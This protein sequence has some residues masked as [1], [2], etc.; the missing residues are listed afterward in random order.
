M[1]RK[2]KQEGNPA[3]LVVW[4][5][6]WIVFLLTI[7]A[8]SFI[9]LG[10]LICEF[11]YARH[12]RTPEEV[13]ILRDAEE[14]RELSENLARTRAID[15]RLGQIEVEGQQLRRRKDGLFHA[16]S[17]LGAR[18]NAEIATL[19]EERSD[20]QAICHELWQLPEQRLREWS[21]P[22]ARLLGFRWAISTYIACLAYGSILMP[23]SAMTLH[24]VILR[25]LSDSLPAVSFPLYGAMALASVVAICAGGGAYVFYSRFIQ[26]HY[27]RQL[28]AS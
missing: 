6:G 15:A 11:L 5:L 24:G 3:G 22:L 17:A 28:E 23:S 25:N 21:A 14:E 7:L 27:T 4:L 26:D 12:P 1:S 2:K 8:T 13:E 16:G 18:L 9:W 10:W 19:T 20:C